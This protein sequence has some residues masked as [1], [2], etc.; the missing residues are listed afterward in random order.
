ML[1]SPQIPLQLEP[2]RDRDFSQFVPGNNAAAVSAIRSIVEGDE[3]QAFLSGPASSGKSHLLNA[4]CLMA[5]RRG[6]TAFYSGL[7]HLPEDG[8]AVFEGLEQMNLICLDDVHGVLG[9]PQWDEALF[10]C[11]NRIRE[12]GGRCVLSSETPLKALELTLPDLGSRLQ[13]GLRLKLQTLEDS[14]KRLVLDQ[15]AAALGI[16]L[17]TEVGDYLIQRS[18]RDLGEL[19]QL[20][21][22]M[23][24]AAFTAK[25]RITIPLA[26]EILNRPNNA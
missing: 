15:H 18:S 24:Q 21:E 12:Q 11:L 19:I 4:L 7:Q 1:F 13:W 26:R 20:L 6:M 10:H 8:H 2:R 14:D 9:N 23:Q 5:R 22:R 25:R 16:H 17:P 3:T